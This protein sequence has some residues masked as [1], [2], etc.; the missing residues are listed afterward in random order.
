V[1]ELD[2]KVLAARCASIDYHRS[3]TIQ[4]H[5]AMLVLDADL[6]VVYASTNAAASLP[7]RWSGWLPTS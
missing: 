7:D 4:P 3:S 5:L 1:S 6:R 2:Q